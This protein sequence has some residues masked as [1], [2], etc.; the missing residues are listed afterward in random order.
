MSQDANS[1]VSARQDSHQS[2]RVII[3][4]VAEADKIEMAEVEIQGISIMQHDLGGGS[5]VPEQL[6]AFQAKVQL[7]KDGQAMLG[8]ER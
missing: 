8:P 6:H 4:A 7:Q 2:T 5:R 3:M 1:A